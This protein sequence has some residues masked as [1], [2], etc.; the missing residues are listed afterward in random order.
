MLEITYNTEREAQTAIAEYIDENVEGFR[1]NQFSFEDAYQ[2]I[3]VR[4]EGKP[5]GQGKTLCIDFEEGTLGLYDVY[6][7]HRRLYDL[8]DLE[9][10]DCPE[11]NH[12]YPEEIKVFREWECSPDRWDL[13]CPEEN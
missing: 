3:L 2:G 9:W 8:S 6:T 13:S 10:F 1:V 4:E 5:L 11:I 12:H 7:L